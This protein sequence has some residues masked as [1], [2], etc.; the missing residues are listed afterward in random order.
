M[1]KYENFCSFVSSHF[2]VET[3]SS[4]FDEKQRIQIKCKRFGHVSEL[5]SG[6]FLNKKSKIPIDR[7][8]SMCTAVDD[9]A[10][11]FVEFKADIFERLGHNVLTVDW[12]L[13]RVTYVCGNCGAH[14]QNAPGNMSRAEATNKCVKCQN[15]DNRL[16]YDELQQK[17]ESVGM[18]L[19]TKPDDYTNNKQ[20][21]ELLCICGGPYSATLSTI[22]NKKRHC[23]KCR[24]HVSNDDTKEED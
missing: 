21:L 11:R 3:S 14:A 7:F 15:I 4:E 18:K 22:I 13:K 17:V 23:M 20:L 8:C 2:T 6:A 9:D 24:G 12:K 19:L 16:K 5:S 1:G 10:D